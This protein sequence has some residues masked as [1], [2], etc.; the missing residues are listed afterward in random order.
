MAKFNG[1]S[2]HSAAR[3][4]EKSCLVCNK[5]FIP[6]SGINKFCSTQCKGK[7]KYITGKGST[8][9]QYKEIS[10]NWRRYLH[11]LLYS[12]GRKRD[13]LTIDILL[14]ILERQN[15]LC[16]LSGQPLTCIL[17]K[18]KRIK[19]NASVDRIIPGGPYTDNN[20]QLVCRALNSW[21]AD[22]SV[23]EFTEWCKKVVEHQTRK[24]E[25]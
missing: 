12:G 6:K 23:N 21:R 25:R 14:S 1:V 11:R 15:H 20:I 16:A 19:T 10:N 4:S 24:K 9:N 17:E 3:V 2:F 22:L 5:S 8:D 13:G 7:W 18:G